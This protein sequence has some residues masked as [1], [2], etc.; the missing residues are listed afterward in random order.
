MLYSQHL[1][2]THLR[3]TQLLLF[4][5]NNAASGFNVLEQIP[6]NV[7]KGF[8]YYILESDMERAEFLCW[9]ED[10]GDQGRSLLD[11]LDLKKR[12]IRDFHAL[13]KLTDEEKQ[14]LRTHKIEQTV[15]RCLLGRPQEISL[16]QLLRCVAEREPSRQIAELWIKNLRDY[17]ETKPET[18]L[19]NL[20]RKRATG[21]ARKKIPIKKGAPHG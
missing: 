11:S 18:Q 13:M 7:F 15:F 21:T 9:L 20:L 3:V 14:I 10:Q 16:S 12:R 19:L 4:T 8:W 2:E 6:V 17:P 1:L 5:L